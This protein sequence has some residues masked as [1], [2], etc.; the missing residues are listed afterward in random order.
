MKLTGPPLRDLFASAVDHSLVRLGVAR[1]L[2]LDRRLVVRA[3]VVLGQRES[4]RGEVLLEPVQLGC[5]R[6]KELGVLN[7]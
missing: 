1:A 4:R 5:A 7:I 3:H 2:R 6:D